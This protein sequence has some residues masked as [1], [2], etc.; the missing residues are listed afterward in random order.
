MIELKK[1]FQP[2]HELFLDLG[3]I[4]KDYGLNGDKTK[5]VRQLNIQSYNYKK[6]DSRKGA[7]LFRI[8]KRELQRR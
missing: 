7:R 4:L 5:T 6:K 8:I 2:R 3:S 1:R